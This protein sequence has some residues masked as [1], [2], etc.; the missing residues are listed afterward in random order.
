M[1]SAGA[2]GLDPAVQAADTLSGR[3]D[4]PDMAA[5]GMLARRL[6]HGTEPVAANVDL[7]VYDTFTTVDFNTGEVA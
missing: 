3:W 4:R 5:V 2:A 7:S 1:A 6:A